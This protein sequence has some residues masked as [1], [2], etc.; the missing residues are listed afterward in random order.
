[1]PV[2]YQSLAAETAAADAALQEILDDYAPMLCDLTGVGREWPASYWSPWEKTRNGS[3]PWRGFALPIRA[4]GTLCTPARTAADRA[5]TRIDRATETCAPY[6]ARATGSQPV[7][8][9]A[10]SDPSDLER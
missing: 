9:G 5:R 3:L 1:L 10:A 6:P 4:S 8:G 2:R 7:H